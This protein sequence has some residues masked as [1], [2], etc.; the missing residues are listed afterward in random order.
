MLSVT[1]IM[2][3]STWQVERSSSLSKDWKA[4]CLLL[5]LALLSACKVDF[6]QVTYCQIRKAMESPVDTDSLESMARLKAVM[7]APQR[8]FTTLFSDLACTNC[9]RMGERRI[10]WWQFQ[11]QW[12]S[13]VAIS[14]WVQLGPPRSWEPLKKS[15]D[16]RVWW[17]LSHLQGCSTLLPNFAHNYKKPLSPL[18]S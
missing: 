14:E 18:N 6:V 9:E 16:Q 13:C 15:L 7:G 10:L 12:E 3:L 5:D 17:R 2:M 1:W 11:E 4:A 8:N